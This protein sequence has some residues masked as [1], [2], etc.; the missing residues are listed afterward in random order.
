M[1][2]LQ[3]LAPFC[4]RVTVV[5]G[6]HRASPSAALDKA[7]HYAIG[8][9]IVILTK[10]FENAITFSVWSCLERSLQ[11]SGEFVPF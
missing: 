4:N 9:N 10:F 2:V 7:V 1:Q 8:L 6:L 5:A 3:E 11:F